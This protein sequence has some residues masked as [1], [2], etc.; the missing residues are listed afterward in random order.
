MSS[1]VTMLYNIV[2]Y[3]K[4]IIADIDGSKSFVVFVMLLRFTPAFWSNRR[5]H[6]GFLCRILPNLSGV[7]VQ[8]TI[9]SRRN[10]SRF[11]K[12]STRS[13]MF[14]IMERH[15]WKHFRLAWN[16]KGSVD[17]IWIYSLCLSPRLRGNRIVEKDLVE[18]GHDKRRKQVPPT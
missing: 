6:L 7:L 9:G 12:T 16:E 18:L 4:F 3:L 11:K 14:L 13:W 8:Q 1:R 10:D 15:P 5:R 17:W 2:K